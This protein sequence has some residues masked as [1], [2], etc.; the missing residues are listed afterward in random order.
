METP[1]E[2]FFL[3]LLRGE[4]FLNVYLAAE[5]DPVGRNRFAGLGDGE[6]HYRSKS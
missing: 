6:D 4:E 1:R 2:V 3:F 5:N